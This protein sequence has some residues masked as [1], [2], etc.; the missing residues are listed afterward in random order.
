MIKLGN[1]GFD[2]LWQPSLKTETATWFQI[3]YSYVVGEEIQNVKAVWDQ[4]YLFMATIRC[5]QLYATGCYHHD[6]GD[7][8]TIITNER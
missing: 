8:Y 4:R 1:K 7:E 2:W 3:G 6:W 5:R